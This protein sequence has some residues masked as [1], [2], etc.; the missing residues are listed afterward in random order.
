MKKSN[1]IT[2]HLATIRA[3]LAKKVPDDVSLVDEL[4][5][6]RREEAVR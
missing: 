3:I 5:K 2:Q 1:N 6:S 4:I